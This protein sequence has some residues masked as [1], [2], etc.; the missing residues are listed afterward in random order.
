MFSVRIKLS[1]L[2]KRVLLGGIVHLFTLLFDILLNY[3]VDRKIDKNIERNLDT[4]DCMYGKA[5]F[6]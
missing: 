4:Y 5:S 2:L 6:L 1:A 3:T